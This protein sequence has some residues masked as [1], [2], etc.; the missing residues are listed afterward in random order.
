MFEFLIRGSPEPPETGP[1]RRR[2]GG[3]GVASPCWQRRCSRVPELQSISRA[4]S[5]RRSLPSLP[6]IDRFQARDGTW[7]GFR[8]YARGWHADRPRGNRDPRLLRLQRRHHPCAVAGTG[9]ARPWKPSRSICAATA[10]QARAAISAMSASLRTIWPISSRVAQHRAVSAAD[11]CWPFLR[12][13]L[14]AARGG[15]RRS[16]T[17]S[18]AS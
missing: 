16:R 3:A 13:R 5:D 11:A 7:L 12:R 6:A 2:R 10:P 18:S 1:E 4:A 15:A 9:S 14:R 17:C 8:H